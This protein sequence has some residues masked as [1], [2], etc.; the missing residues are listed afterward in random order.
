MGD[1]VCGRRFG[2]VGRMARQSSCRIRGDVADAEG[3][4]RHPTAR[5]ADTVVSGP[6][7]PIG[8]ARR[9]VAFGRCR[10]H[11]IFRPHDVGTLENAFRPSRARSRST[12]RLFTTLGARTMRHGTW[13]LFEPGMSRDA[14]RR[15]VA[16][17]MNTGG[18]FSDR[19]TTLRSSSSSS[20]GALCGADVALKTGR[21]SRALV[22]QEGRARGGHGTPDPE[23]GSVHARVKRMTAL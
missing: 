21:P 17:S 2:R 10:G 1:G 9:R 18:G 12:R 22:D 20:I 16:R 7:S 13:K 4:N 5:P 6:Q 14:S 23:T 3:R 15:E 8:A 11:R 19:W